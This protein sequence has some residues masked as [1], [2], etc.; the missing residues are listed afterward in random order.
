MNITI[1]SDL[2][3]ESHLRSISQREVEDFDKSKL[4]I[5]RYDSIRKYYTIIKDEDSDLVL[6]AGDVTGD[7]S[8]G[9]G[10]HYAFILLLKL[11]EE[12]EISSAYIRGNHDEEAYYELVNQFT[13]HLKYAN[14]ISNQCV[15]ILGLKILGIDYQQSKSKTQLKNL[16]A[17]S[18]DIYDIVIAHSQLK[19]RIRLFELQTNYIFTGHYDR[20]LFHFD[21]STYISLDNDVYEISYATLQ[22]KENESDLLSIK[23]KESNDVT[24]SLDEEVNYLK[25]GKRT[26]KISINGIPTLEID[27]IEKTHLNALTEGTRDY[28]YLKFIRGLAYQKSLQTLQ[29]IKANQKLENTDLELKEVI[30]LQIIN[31][32]RISESLIEDYLGNVL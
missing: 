30:K 3:W 5:S 26:N 10:F 9:H 20:K 8:C 21:Q 32:Y 12:D 23:I 11:L 7:G 22:K 25:L 18:D 14:E 24:L 28:S 6:F 2:N 27:P 29:K 31:N 16:L 4:N 17:T 15:V 13:N 1:L 19:R